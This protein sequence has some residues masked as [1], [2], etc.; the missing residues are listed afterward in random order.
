MLEKYRTIWERYFE[1]YESNEAAKC[2]RDIKEKTSK[3]EEQGKNENE[4]TNKSRGSLTSLTI[5]LPFLLICNL[6]Q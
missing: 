6:F 4:Q 2:L 1:V 3:F 5:I